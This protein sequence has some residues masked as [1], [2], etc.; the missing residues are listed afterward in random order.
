MRHHNGKVCR[1]VPWHRPS[2]TIRQP[3]SQVRIDGEQRAYWKRLSLDVMGRC[4][5]CG[6]LFGYGKKC[7]SCGSTMTKIGRD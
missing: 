7:R 2:E 6:D 4:S 5:N 3:E 1:V